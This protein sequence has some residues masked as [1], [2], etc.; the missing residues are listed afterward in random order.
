[1]QSH[2]KL[3][4]LFSHSLCITGASYVPQALCL[5]HKQPLHKPAFFG[6]KQAKTTSINQCLH[7]ICQNCLLQT[8]LKE[9]AGPGGPTESHSHRTFVNNE[10]ALGAAELAQVKHGHMVIHVHGMLEGA[11]VLHG[12]PASQTP[13]PLSGA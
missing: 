13:M 4:S 2:H 9:R 1:M 5:I 7:V 8:M 6:L 12:C 10:L 3:S 11:G